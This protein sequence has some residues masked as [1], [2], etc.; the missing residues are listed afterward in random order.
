MKLLA[1]KCP[2][3]GQRLAP[4]SKQALVMACTNCDTAVS[5]DPDKGI[6]ETTLQ[7]ASPKAEGTEKWLPM[8]VFD[9]K[10]NITSRRTRK[11][12]GRSEKASKEFWGTPR[13]LYVPAWTSNMQTARQLG[14]KLVEKQPQFQTIEKPNGTSLSEMVVAEEDALKLIEFIVMSIEAERK[15]WLTDLQFDVKTQMINLWAIPAK[16]NKNGWGLLI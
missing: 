11:R 15:D 5:I 16:K 14:T 7:F 3:C 4:K 8:W 1:L 10:V 13:R 6:Q 12:D 9:A 2:V